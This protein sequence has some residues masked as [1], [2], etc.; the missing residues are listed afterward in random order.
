MPQ[1]RD[2]GCDRHICHDGK[3]IVYPVQPVCEGQGKLFALRAWR[4]AGIA[5]GDGKGIVMA[6]QPTEIRRQIQR[7]EAAR[8]ELIGVCEGARD[9]FRGYAKAHRAKGTQDGE[10]K[11]IQN[12]HYADRLQEAIDKHKSKG[13]T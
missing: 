6:D 1:A 12:D 11:A 3:A 13:K 10:F 9:V 8:A 5:E 4:I 2:S 7:A